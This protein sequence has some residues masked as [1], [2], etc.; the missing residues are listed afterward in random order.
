MISS[1]LDAVTGA[2]SYTGKYITRRLLAL[3]R[4]VRSLTGQPDRPNPLGDL[5]T[6][7][8]FRFDDHRAL[9]RSL[10]GAKVLYNTYWVRFSHGRETYEGAVANT[11]ALIAAAKEAGV[12]RIVHVS[13]T[14]PDEDSPLPYFKGKGTIERAIANSGLSYAILRPA[15]IFGPEDILINNIAWLLRHFPFFTVPG[16]GDYGL[17]PIF[18]EDMAELAVAA[19]QRND[20]VMLNAVGPRTYSFNELVGLVRD[21]V[22]SRARVIHIHPAA[23]YLMSRLISRMVG[24]VVLTRDEVQGLMANLLIVHTPPTGKRDLGEWLQQNSKTVGTRYASELARHYR[25]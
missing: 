23:A 8:S 18:V 24:D 2:T 9:A 25:P 22:G 20:N 21:T 17:Q 1:Q 14:N 3:G 16:S 19:G 4:Q 13:I 11:L 5:V 10:E 12:E 15:V 7:V 6:A